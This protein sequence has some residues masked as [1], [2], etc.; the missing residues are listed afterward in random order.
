MPQWES[1]GI[2][3]SVPNHGGNPSGALVAC[4]VSLQEGRHQLSF[5]GVFGSRVESAPID[6]VVDC[7]APSVSA[8]SIVQ[9]AD[10]DGINEQERSNAGAASG[11]ARVSVRVDTVGMEDG[12]NLRILSESGTI[13]ANGLVNGNTTTIAVELNDGARRVYATGADAVGNPLPT[14]GAGFVDANVQIDTV[15]DAIFGQCQRS[16][17]PECACG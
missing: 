10:N 16:R 1:F 11:T 2:G 12:Q 4:P 17:L 3:R 15:P 7:E 14:E 5:V 6:L 9:D 13:L 8:V